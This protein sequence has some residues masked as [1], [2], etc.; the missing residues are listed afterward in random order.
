LIAQTKI[1]ELVA[2]SIIELAQGGVRTKDA[3]YL[4]TMEQFKAN[5]Q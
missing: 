2:R 1:P 3:L 4:R 5:L